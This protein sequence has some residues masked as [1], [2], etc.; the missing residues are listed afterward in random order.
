MNPHEIA[1]ASNL[2]FVRYG[3]S[4][5]AWDPPAWHGKAERVGSVAL[6]TTS[7]V[8]KTP[9]LIGQ[10]GGVKSITAHLCEDGEVLVDNA[11][12][13][14]AGFAVCTRCGYAA[15]EEHD[16]QKGLVKLPK[17]FRD[18]IPLSSTKG[19]CFDDGDSSQPMRNV[20]LAARQNT[21][22]L[23]LCLAGA[24]TGAAIAI[25]HAMIL[26][27]ADLLEL[28]PREMDMFVEG[29]TITLF[30]TA[31]GGCGHMAD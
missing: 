19:S 29:N 17:G 2:V 4:T 16:R 7:F 13:K 27:A 21:D 15:S 22:L 3:F 10:F 5:A 30:E 18:H 12:E 9:E 1:P 23:R 20:H 6:G 31:A 26:A 8:A 11:G 14:G 25:G 24:T 28:D